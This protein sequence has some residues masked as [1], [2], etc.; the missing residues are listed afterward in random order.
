MKQTHQLLEKP[1][2]PYGFFFMD[3]SLQEHFINILNKVVFNFVRFLGCFFDLKLK[4]I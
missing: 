1:N 4:N 3:Y 2:L